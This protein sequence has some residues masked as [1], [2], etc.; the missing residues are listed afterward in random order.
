MPHVI[1]QTDP[2]SGYLEWKEQ[3]DCAVS[4]VLARGR[5]ILGPE[6]EAFEKAFAE[7]LG[8]AHGVGVAN[9]T[10]A[11]ELALRA[12]G[13]GAGDFVVTV[14]NTAS[15]TATAIARTGARIVLAEVDEETF[16]VSP[17]T[18]RASFDEFAGLPIKAVV[19]VAL[20]GHPL[21]PE[22]ARI[23]REKG[24]RYIEDC[25]Q[26]HGARWD[27]I[28]AGTAGDFGAF[29]F[30]PTKNLGAIGDG[31]IAVTNDPALAQR[32]R[33]L[34]E[35]GWRERYVSAEL[36]MNSRLDPLQ[37]AILSAKLPHLDGDNERRR[38]L[39]AIYDE[40]IV[41][42]DV[43]KP[44]VAPKAAH[45][46]HQYVIRSPRRDALRE[47]LTRHEVGTLIHYPVPIHQQPGLRPFCELPAG[48]LALSERLSREI[49]SLPLFPQL[50]IASAET[51]AQ[52]INDFS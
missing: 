37:A 1:L 10:D 23:S 46:F 16:N 52:R 22:L 20:Y 35:Y 19:A 9:G 2:R 11:I 48:G 24:L 40:A 26:A 21:P 49:I 45:V 15:A 38:A 13:I 14:A 34:R 25:A 33:E 7:W 47:G 36:G 12:C 31:G 8:V 43:Q 6:V 44:R 32:A 17:A 18:L 5:Y 41:A 4:Q 28:A 42:A 39:A 27:G 3:I 29:S 51:V 30:Y 50:P